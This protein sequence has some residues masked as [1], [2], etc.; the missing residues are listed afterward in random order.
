MAASEPL[1]DLIAALTRLPGIGA[2][3]A[4]RLACT[5]PENAR[6]EADAVRQPS[7]SVRIASPTAR[8]A[9]TS[10][11]KIPC[12]LCLSPDRDSRI[13]C[14]VEQPE[15]VGA[16]EKTRGFR[17]RY[18]VLLGAIAPAGA[19]G[20]RSQKEPL[21][22]HQ[23]QR[24]SESRGG[25]RRHES[26]CRGEATALTWARLLKP[27]ASASV[28]SRWAFLSAAT[29]T[30]PT[31]SRCPRQWRDGGHVIVIGSCPVLSQNHSVPPPSTRGTRAVR[32]SETSTP[33]P[34]GNQS[35]RPTSSEPTCST[36]SCRGITLKKAFVSL[37]TVSRMN[38]ATGS[39]CPVTSQSVSHISRKLRA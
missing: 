37:P 3:S 10:P 14:V 25:H 26:Q 11:P 21:D 8:S 15:N 9:A 24:R 32:I 2:R 6:E 34:G 19:S 31:S 36:P 1:G 7:C 29:S 23:R 38:A 22:A 17:G 18:H 12:A 27:L 13:L 5:H 30:T 35:A 16:I 20:R 4:T 28:A 39:D 33:T